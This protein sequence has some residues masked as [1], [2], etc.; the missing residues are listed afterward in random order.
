MLE[1]YAHACL[2]MSENK[3][4]DQRPERYVL[5]VV[6]LSYYFFF[7]LPSEARIKSCKAEVRVGE[8]SGFARI[9]FQC[10]SG[11]GSGHWNN[12]HPNSSDDPDVAATQAVKPV[13]NARLHPRAA[14]KGSDS[15]K[16]W[17]GRKG[18]WL[19]WSA[20]MCFW[21]GSN[22]VYNHVVSK[23]SESDSKSTN[24]KRRRSRDS[25]EPDDVWTEHVSSSGRTYFYNKRWD[26]SQWERP[27]GP[28]K[29]S[30]D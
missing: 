10:L 27:D 11:Q 3:Q 17:H 22:H 16:S 29:K 9:H 30:V 5:L 2:G 4:H 18:V 15:R 19:G 23:G 12:H 26:K 28:I 1:V 24:G 13:S 8:F 6:A 14:L 20:D 7:L 25:E 21:T